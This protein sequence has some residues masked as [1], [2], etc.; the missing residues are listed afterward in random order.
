MD[1]GY[2]GM[3]EASGTDVCDWLLSDGFEARLFTFFPCTDILP[4]VANQVRGVW[5]VK[6]GRAAAGQHWMH[7][8]QR[9]LDHY[10]LVMKATFY[11]C[12]CRS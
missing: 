12:A 9:R 2:T 10:E 8:Q 11:H 7:A 1:G 4:L 6:E 3:L 5:C